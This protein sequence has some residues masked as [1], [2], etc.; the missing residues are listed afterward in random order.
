MILMWIL[1]KYVVRPWTA[2]NLLKIGAVMGFVIIV[3]KLEVL[4]FRDVFNVFSA[5]RLEQGFSTSGPHVS[6]R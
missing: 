5:E 6:L 2:L 4:F 3:L 1:E